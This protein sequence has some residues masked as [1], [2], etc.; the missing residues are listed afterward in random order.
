MY[1]IEVWAVF[2]LLLYASTEGGN[3]GRLQPVV[4]VAVREEMSWKRIWRALEES[5]ANMEW[6]SGLQDNLQA[7]NSAFKKLKSLLTEIGIR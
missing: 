2:I 7:R 5:F 4:S 6:E 1:C 3:K